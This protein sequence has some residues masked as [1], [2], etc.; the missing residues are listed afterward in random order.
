MFLLST[1]SG[2]IRRKNKASN[3]KSLYRKEIE[4]KTETIETTEVETTSE[5]PS[6]QDKMIEKVAIAVAAYAAVE[7]AKILQKK[8]VTWH[9]NR[10]SNNVIELV[11]TESK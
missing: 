8:V 9:R 5:T 10:K 1:Q 11:P 2:P 7:V 6:F 4:M 3:E